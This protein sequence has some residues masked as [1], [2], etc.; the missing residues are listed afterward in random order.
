[1]NR[2]K[3]AVRR[4]P[5]KQGISDSQVLRVLKAYMGVARFAEQTF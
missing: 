1:M 5:T 4:K 2:V 3:E